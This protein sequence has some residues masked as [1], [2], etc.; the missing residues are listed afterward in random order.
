LLDLIGICRYNHD[1]IENL[2]RTEAPIITSVFTD[3]L[4]QTHKAGTLLEV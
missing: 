4:F 3:L 2:D 1:I